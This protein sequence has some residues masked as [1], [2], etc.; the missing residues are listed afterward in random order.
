MYLKNPVLVKKKNV[1]KLANLFT[2]HQNRI[3]NEDR[4]RRLTTASTSEMVHSVNALILDDIR[5][6]IDSFSEQQEISVDTTH[7]TELLPCLF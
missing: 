6:S 5:L 4:P 7:Q 1:Y 3:Y 2:E